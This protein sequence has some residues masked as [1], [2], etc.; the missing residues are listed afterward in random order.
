MAMATDDR[1][2]KLAIQRSGAMV[3]MGLVDSPGYFDPTPR[4][5]PPGL[6]K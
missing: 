1:D 5:A 6:L 4:I 2:F 3:H